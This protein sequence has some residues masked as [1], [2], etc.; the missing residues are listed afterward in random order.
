MRRRNYGRTFSDIEDNLE[1][2]N[3]ER[4]SLKLI[5]KGEVIIPPTLQNKV[6]KLNDLPYLVRCLRPAQS[7]VCTLSLV[8][9]LTCMY[10]SNLHFRI[11]VWPGH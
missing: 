1:L 5:G 2:L 8:R 11:Q 3:D 4:F 6:F 7:L 10:G 9:I